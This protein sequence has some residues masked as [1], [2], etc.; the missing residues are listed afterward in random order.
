[1]H[2]PSVSSVEYLGYIVG[3]SGI[4]MDESKVTSILEWPKPKSVKGVQSFVGF[5]DFY[6]RF[7][8]D[9]SK[10]VTPMTSLNKKRLTFRLE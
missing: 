9:Y 5:A 7:I 10:V 6:R 4:S 8:R 2:F 1:M 3:A